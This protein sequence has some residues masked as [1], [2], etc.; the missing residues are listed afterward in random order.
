MSGRPM[1]RHDSFRRPS[2]F[3]VFSFPP[4]SAPH[5]GA[6]PFLSHNPSYNRRICQKTPFDVSPS[7]SFVPTFLDIPVIAL[8]ASHPSH[9]TLRLSLGL[10]SPLLPTALPEIFYSSAT[11][12]PT[13]AFVDPSLCSVLI[14]SSPT[15]HLAPSV[16]TEPPNLL[17]FF[18]G[19]LLSRNSS[20]CSK[21]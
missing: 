9:D 1:S 5:N 18:V 7:S 19:L 2:I 4:W 17:F 8:L 11:Y 6:N 20:G 16:G 3:K 15:Q 10:L 13:V 21:Y 12:E 14:H